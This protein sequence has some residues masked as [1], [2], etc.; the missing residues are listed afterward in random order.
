MRV[1]LGRLEAN[2]RFCLARAAKEVNIFKNGGK[3]VVKPPLGYASIGVEKACVGARLS[4]AIRRTQSVLPMI[5]K[6]I[7]SWE[8]GSADPPDDSVL[9][10]DFVEGVEISAEVFATNGRYDLLGFCEKS[11]MRPPFFEEVSYC[12]PARRLPQRQT[13][14]RAALYE[15]LAALGFTDG[16]AHCELI[17][18]H[19]RIVLL[20]VGLRLG[21]SGLS[22]DLVYHSSGIP[23]AKAALTRLIG[24]DPR[25]FLASDR[26]DICL[27]YLYQVGP[28]GRVSNMPSV[29]ESLRQHLIRAVDFVHPGDRLRGYPRY[30]GLPGYALFRIQGRG[31]TSYATVD[32]IL[33]DC[34]EKLAISY[35]TSR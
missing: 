34:R 17:I 20:D 1:S 10:E 11:P 16:A 5:K 15:A 2:P 7:P 26:K 13:V 24:C 33:N 31:R 4:S 14:I 35:T 22:H 21:G 28:G 23:L 8:C 25:K 27:L 32:R 19:R 29:P 9:V 6:S 30:S 12:M 18:S 3:V